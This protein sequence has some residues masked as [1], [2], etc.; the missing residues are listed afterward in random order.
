MRHRDADAGDAAVTCVQPCD[1]TSDAISHVRAKNLSL[2]VHDCKQVPPGS[3]QRG[4][5]QGKEWAEAFVV[6]NMAAVQALNE[7]LLA[8]SGGFLEGDEV[9]RIVEAHA[10]S[11]DLETMRARNAESVLL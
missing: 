5:V 10:D 11:S 4:G 8:A 1:R 6:R 2:P 9:H 7:A 3:L